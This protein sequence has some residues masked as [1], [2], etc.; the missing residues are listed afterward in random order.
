M[1]KVKAVLS[2][3]VNVNCPYCDNYINLMN[4]EETGANLNDESY[5][6]KQACPINGEHWMDAHERFEVDEVTCLECGGEFSV[7]KMEW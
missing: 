3:E 7:N 4:E 6:L 5:I 2:I 1:K